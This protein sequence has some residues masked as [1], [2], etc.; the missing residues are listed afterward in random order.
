MVLVNILLVSLLIGLQF[1]N[2]LEGVN[3]F[4][5][6]KKQYQQNVKQGWMYLK[7]K[8]KFSN[9]KPSVKNRIDKMLKSRGMVKTYVCLIILIIFIMRQSFVSISYKYILLITMF[10]VLFKILYNILL[11]ED[12]DI[13]FGSILYIIYLGIV[14]FLSLMLVTIERNGFN[15]PSFIITLCLAFFT[16]L[17]SFKLFLNTNLMG[18]KYDIV[19]WCLMFYAIFVLLLGYLLIGYGTL[20]YDLKINNIDAEKF[21][22]NVRGIENDE[23]TLFLSFLYHGVISFKDMS[24]LEMV[25]IKSSKVDDFIDKEVLLF[26]LF[27][28]AF[29]FTYIS[30]IIAFFINLFTKKKKKVLNN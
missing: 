18:I 12:D 7:E 8:V 11:N 4:K 27:S 23:F 24:A 16:L 28:V 15:N 9:I 25:N 30:T 22:W 19:L 1:Y 3:Q 26:R 6:N 2:I 5:R 10:L 13:N 21:A 17:L 29:V 20:Y 14:I